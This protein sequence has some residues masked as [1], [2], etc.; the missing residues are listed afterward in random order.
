MRLDRESFNTDSS[1][2]SSAKF[3]GQPE[4][5]ITFFHYVAEELRT[6]M[7][8]LGFRTI[9][10][11]VGRS[12]YLRVDDTLRNPKTANLDLSALL[13]PAWEM[14]PGVATYKVRAQD[15][16]LHIRLDNKFILESEPALEKGVPVL[17]E[18]EVVNTDRALGTTLSN[19]VS[20]RYGEEGLPKD[21]I[22]I[23]A[24]GSAGQS[25]GAFLAP[26]ITI[27]LEGDANDYVGK[28]LSGG[29]LIV[30][31]PK[32]STF[33]PEEVRPFSFS[34]PLL[35]SLSFL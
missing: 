15:H 27:E 35:G 17:I 25:L 20:K 7:A 31:P 16:R 34:V 30:Y 11:M 18:C 24:T 14:R 3:T 2:P 8:R 23:N 26:G 4:H 9:N 12:D 33:K 19:H 13:K 22:H 21:T 1:F 10:E 28:G 5:V 32:A 29:R 6:Y